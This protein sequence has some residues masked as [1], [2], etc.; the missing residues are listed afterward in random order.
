[1]TNESKDTAKPDGSNAKI[2]YAEK[3]NA[4]VKPDSA[5]PKGDE[6]RELSADERMI[7]N[8]KKGTNY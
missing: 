1:L 2:K 5:E 3:V 6:G 8:Q 4:V 7:S